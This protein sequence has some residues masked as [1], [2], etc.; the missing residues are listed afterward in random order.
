MSKKRNQQDPIAQLKHQGIY[1]SHTTKNKLNL[2]F[3]TY[4]KKSNEL[5]QKL[6][7]HLEQLEP[8]TLTDQDKKTLQLL[9]HLIVF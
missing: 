6:A 3:I 2:S 5:K 8:E 1:I 7:V 4:L 9:Q